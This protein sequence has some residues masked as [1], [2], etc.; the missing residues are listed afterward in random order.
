ME[1][2]AKLVKELRDRTGAG[3]MDAKKAL[4]EAGGDLDKAVDVLRKTG[5]AKADKKLDREAKEGKV[6]SWLADDRKRG[7]LL[8]LNCETDFVSRTDE[9]NA[10]LG[11]LVK[12]V[13]DGKPRDVDALSATNL[14]DFGNQAVSDIIKEH[15]ARMGENIRV[16]RF[17]VYEAEPG[18][19]VEIY[20]HPGDM[21]G[22]MLAIQAPATEAGQEVARNIA[23]QI[24][25]MEPYA[26]SREEIPG[27]ILE[28]EKEIYRDQALKSGKPEKI[29]EK[30]VEGKLRLFYEE[31]ALIE[32]PY[33]K[34]QGLTVADYLAR[35]SQEINSPVR[36]LKFTRFKV[37][38]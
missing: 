22:V 6:G 15:I 11:A 1:I 18:A 34:E 16:K 23:M 27:E 26:V 5:L 12:A 29:L 8:E 17:A 2:P 24:A 14:P 28:K 36:V 13:R 20:I 21:L 25:A 38:E 33:V 10:L 32:Q 35:V 7:L 19:I 3:F 31:R 9:F 37:G 30:I 4:Q